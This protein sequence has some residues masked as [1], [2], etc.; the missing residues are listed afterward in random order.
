MKKIIKAFMSA[1]L[2]V[3]LFSAALPAYAY[4]V[5]DLP[6]TMTFAEALEIYDVSE[7]KSATVSDLND[8]KYITLTQEE[9]KDLYF[10]KSFKSKLLQ[11]YFTLVKP[12]F[13]PAR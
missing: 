4:N 11:F 2:A 8:D 6:S 1:L 10:Y 3:A 5:V 9:I 13:L 7:I 12:I